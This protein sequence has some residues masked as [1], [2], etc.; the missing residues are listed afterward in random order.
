MSIDAVPTPFSPGI[1]FPDVRRIVR[2]I[3][4]ANGPQAL[5]DE[6]LQAQLRSARKS[7]PAT[8]AVTLIAAASVL[9]ANTGAENFD[10]IATAAALL[11]TVILFNVLV[12]WRQRETDWQFSEPRATV[13]RTALLAFALSV[14]W[15]IM[16]ATTL[17]EAPPDGLMLMLCVIVGV[18]AAG[19]LNV[20]VLP[21]ASLAF[22]LGSLVTIG[23]DIFFLTALPS[24]VG[25][26]LGVFVF[27]LARSILDQAALFVENFEASSM[28]LKAS[29]ER[30]EIARLARL[31]RDRLDVRAAADRERLAEAQAE[32]REARDRSVEQRRNDVTAIAE[33]IELTVGQALGTLGGAAATSQRNASL[34]ADLCVSDLT[35]ADR[36]VK[37]AMRTSERAGSLSRTAVE[38]ER[39]AASV[40]E[41]VDRQAQ[42]TAHAA[43]EAKSSE[44]TINA[45]VAN[46]LDIGKIVAL[47][48]D[49]A[50]QTNLL[51]LNAGI[52]AA[53][54]GDAG[55]GFAVVA[56]EVKNLA[57]QTQRATKEIRRQVEGVR[58]S[59][60]SAAANI[61]AVAECNSKI[62]SLADEISAAT[63]VQRSVTD[64]IVADAGLVAS[65]IDKLS[66][67]AADGAANAERTK[68]LTAEAAGSTQMIH[69]SVRLLSSETRLL[70]SDLGT[71]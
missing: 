8:M 46:A 14:A 1:R 16:L 42:L 22:L 64:S 34:L 19:V 32:A 58:D 67:D 38:L 35:F 60:G 5:P 3:G 69:D 68:Q 71:A 18:T 6:V 53:R 31:E 70:L 11:F 52:E 20:A 24:Q 10:Q 33:K 47:I 45:L 43:T 40:V 41:R 26:L 44:V 66:A 57:G 7:T 56:E 9:A 39:S 27:V 62:A 23:F 30:E 55:R 63:L 25:W 61:H 2:L 28:L 51:A 15:G 4:L 29:L 17:V 59:V 48:D 21:L 13:V 36:I 49:V 50:T 54:A 12:W 65:G 37:A